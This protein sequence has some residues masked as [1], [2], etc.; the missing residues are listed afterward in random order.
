MINTL[1]SLR[2]SYGDKEKVAL[3]NVRVATKDLG[4]SALIIKLAG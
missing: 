1:A 3:I 4:R 2:Y